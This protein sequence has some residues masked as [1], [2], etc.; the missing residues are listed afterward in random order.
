MT[1][2]KILLNSTLS[3]ALALELAACATPVPQALEPQHV[4]SHFSS[5]TAQGAPVWPSAG[6]WAGFGSIEL[7]GLIATAQTNNLDLTAAAAR[8]LQAQAQSKISGS[9]LFP[10]V[11]LSGNADRTRSAQGDRTSINNSFGLS[12]DASYQVDLWGRARDNLRAAD[13]LVLASS[14]AQQVVALSVTADVANTYWDVLALRER[15]AIAKQNAEAARR[16]LATVESRVKNGATS[17]LDLAQQET[18]VQAVE[19][20]IPPLEEQEREALFALAILLGRLPEGFDVDG[21]RRIDKIVAPA[22]APGLP[23]H[24]LRRRPDVAE[25]EAN[26]ASAHANVDAA[27]AAFFPQI[28]LTGSGGFTSAALS[29]LFTGSGFGWTIGSSLA[30]TIFDGGL[31]QGQ[32]E[33]NKARQQELVATYQS[34]VLNAFSDVEKALSQVSSLAK[35]ERQKTAQAKSAAEAFRISELQYRQGETDL[36]SVLTA[37]QTL[38]TAQ[39][40]LV[41]IKLARLQADVG[42]YQALGGGWSEA[43]YAA[44]QAIPVQTTAVEAGPAAT[45]PPEVAPIP[46]TPRPQPPASR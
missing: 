19:A 16:I 3:I 9:A 34:T 40:Q 18:Q 35:Q 26:L 21:N 6:W 44:T 36:L 38:F 13:Q 10:S 7:N 39:D 23:S 15:I 45:V 33:L 25:A 22:V 32:L 41:Q 30:Q 29:S 2:K 11:G 37:Q 31:L 42:L 17:R 8:V 5:P 20:T 46:E 1:I 14:Y 27:R 43:S 12:L 28:G 24:L 4:P